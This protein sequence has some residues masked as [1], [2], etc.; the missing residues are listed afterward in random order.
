MF[1]VG[2]LVSFFVGCKTQIEPVIIKNNEPLNYPETK[3]VDTIDNYFGEN[4][5]DPYRWLEDDRSESTEDWVKAQNKV[6]F[7]YLNEIPFKNKLKDRLSALWNYEKVSAPFKKGEFTYFYKNDGLQNQ[8]VLYRFKKEGDEPEVFLDPNTFSEDGT[9]SLGAV[10]F[11]KNGKLVAY[12]ISEGGSDWRKVIVKNVETKE[13]IEDTLVDIKFSGISWKANDGFYYS[14]YDKPKG[15]ELSAKTD[16]HKVY[17]HKLGTLQK[18]DQLIFGGTEKE[19]HRYIGA[20]VTEDD[21]YLFINAA[22]STSGNKLFLKD[23]TKPDGK[24]VTILDHT[25]SDTYV[26]EN[27]GSKLYLVTNLNAPNKKVV[28]VD[29]SDPGVNNWVD[30][31]PETE[32]VLSPN[33]GGGSFFAEYMVLSSAWIGNKKCIHQ[34]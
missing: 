20:Q 14:S 33:T 25:K 7:G 1:I 5:K 2:L 30:F 15:S 13:V 32:N 11:S 27:V 24:L 28:T 34:S 19:K 8:Y 22:T 12:S 23:L 9:T 26:I 10:N 18:E 21:H 29:A 6:T 17:Y 31:I 3:K 4:I 16:Q